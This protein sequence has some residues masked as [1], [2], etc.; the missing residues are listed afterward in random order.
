MKTFNRRALVLIL[1]VF[2]LFPACKKKAPSVSPTET[3]TTQQIKYTCEMDP[4]VVTDKPGKCPKCGMDLI[5]IK[6]K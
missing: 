2:F 4:D 1:P 6:G 3:G 5:P